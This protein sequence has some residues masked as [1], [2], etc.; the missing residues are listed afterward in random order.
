MYSGSLT[1]DPYSLGPTPYNGG[2]FYGNAD[3]HSETTPTD[4]GV[5][6]TQTAMEIPVT[7]QT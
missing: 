7:S 6:W 3:T 5:V 2:V 4:G 1:N